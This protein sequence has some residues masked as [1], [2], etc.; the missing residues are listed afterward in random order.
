MMTVVDQVGLEI[1]FASQDLR[2]DGEIVTAAI[3]NNGAELV[4][5]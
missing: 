1:K 3:K 4:F 5:A 2:R